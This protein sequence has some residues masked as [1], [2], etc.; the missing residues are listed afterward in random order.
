MQDELTQVQ[1]K[2]ESISR[3]NESLH[4]VNTQLQQKLVVAENDVDYFRDEL[5]SATEELRNSKSSATSLGDELAEVKSIK[6]TLVEEKDDIEN[7]LETLW[8]NESQLKVSG[9]GSHTDSYNLSCIVPTC[10]GG[11]GM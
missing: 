7:E 6:Q 5:T 11:T 2:L 4:V 3:D 8:T 1:S 9:N 10:I